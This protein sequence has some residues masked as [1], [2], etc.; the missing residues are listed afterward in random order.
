MRPGRQ[1]VVLT[2]GLVAALLGAGC[3]TGTRPELVEPAAGAAETL[4][5]APTPSPGDAPN[6]D[7]STDVVG[8]TAP[9]SSTA[10]APALDPAAPVAAPNGITAP[11][12]ALDPAGLADQIVAAERAIRDPAT[13]D[14]VVA[15]MARLQQVAYRKLSYEP[16]WDDQVLALVPPDLAEVVRANVDARREFLGMHTVWPTEVP[17]WRIV[18][19]EPAD[20]LL[21]Y[22]RE[23]E[24]AT[25]IP[26]TYLA[27]INL[28][29]TGMGRI[30]GLS[31]AGAQGP[32][33][34][35]PATWA[36]VGEGDVDDPHDAILA[37]ARYLVR[38]GGPADMDRAL[39]GYNNHDNYV[40][41]VTHYADLMAADEMAFRGFY[42]WEIYFLSELGDLWLPGGYEVVERVPVA[43]YLLD[44]PWSAPPP[45]TFVPAHDLPDA[46]PAG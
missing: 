18:E 26:W 17:D 13:S 43:D 7:P 5:T 30:R 28:V 2:A 45:D 38:R 15:E 3:G 10:A 36:E 33:Q 39:W 34:F 19:P 31:S 1:A 22:Y 40:R 6:A 21:S 25:G 37:A 14:D 11:R 46:A 29:E 27:A 23:A 16:E 44:H 41:A 20:A 35:M 42:H 4:A 12:A 32:M 9:P 24:T 8:D